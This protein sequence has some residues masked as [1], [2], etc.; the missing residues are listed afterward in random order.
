VPLVPEVV[1][2]LHGVPR[3]NAGMLFPSGADNGRAFSAFSKGKERLAALAAVAPFVLHDL[4]RTA[5]TRMAALGV[6]PH[7]VEKL[8]NHTTG[9]LGGVA[10]VYNRFKYR[11][12]VRAA[13]ELWAGHMRELV[14]ADDRTVAALAPN[15]DAAEKGLPLQGEPVHCS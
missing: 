13:L 15:H 6:A 11:D 7:V 2:I 10:G 8:L 1:G 12:E 5:A 4:R 9:I 3:F 14:G